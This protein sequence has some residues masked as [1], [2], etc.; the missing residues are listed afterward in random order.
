M[1]NVS[2]SGALIRTE[3]GIYPSAAILVETLTPALGRA[4]RK[5]PA[6]VMRADCGEIAVE[7]MDLASTA[8]SAVLT[9]TMLTSGRHEDA[10]LPALGR[11]RYCALAPAPAA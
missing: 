10:C 4:E 9:E 2:A 11:V 3:L 6:C 7:W 8:V 1:E 5:L